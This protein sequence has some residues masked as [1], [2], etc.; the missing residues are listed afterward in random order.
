MIS[1]KLL[2]AL[3]FS[4]YI[5]YAITATEIG[6]ALPGIRSELALS[7]SLAGIIASLQSLMIMRERGVLPNR[8]DDLLPT[9]SG[10]V[11]ATSLLLEV[12][13]LAGSP[14]ITPYPSPGLGVTGVN[15]MFCAAMRSALKTLPSR[16]HLNSPRYTL[17]PQPSPCN[18][19]LD[20]VPL[21]S[22]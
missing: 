21:S 15:S 20:E 14:A 5:F 16:V 19:H 2:W 10:E 1:R 7:E 18:G 8:S 11:W 13:P 22:T 3:C 17:I 4:S 9:L 12:Q 6:S